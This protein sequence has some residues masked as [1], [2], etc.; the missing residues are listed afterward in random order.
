LGLYTTKGVIMSPFQ[1]VVTG[2][3]VLFVVAGV[4]IFALF[5]GVLGGGSAGPV[6]IWGT[7]DPER[8]QYLIESLRSQDNDFQDVTYVEKDPDTYSTELLNAMAAGTGP[9]LFIVSQEEIGSFGDKILA[10]PYGTFSQRD[11]VDAFID[12]GQLFLTS[13]GSLALPFMV[14]PLVMYWNRDLFAAST[15]ATPPQYWNELL[16][17]AP[18]LTKQDASQTITQSAVALGAWQNITNAK[19]LL[20]ALFLQAGEPITARAENGSLVPVFGNRTASAEL[21]A[22]SALRFYTEFGN[23]SKSNYTWNR[24]LPSSSDLFASGRLAIYFGFASEYAN[25]AERNPNLR[26]AVALLPQLQ[27]ATKATFGTIRGLAISRMAQ[28]PTGAAI[29]AQKLTAPVASGILSGQTGLPSVRREVALD[30]SANAA[31]TVFVQSALLSRAWIDPDAAATDGIFKAMI[32]SVISGSA[33]PAQA[34]NEAAQ[35]F[36][37]VLPYTSH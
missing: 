15:I 28:N 19:A 20:S 1:I 18:K 21:P 33:T 37:I 34:V 26:F 32:E 22:E 5:G 17:L 24:S 30:T 36:S 4:G 7:I 31:A 16:T 6:A 3:F 25:I 23:P 12:E 14:D 27:G 11:F 8:M 35:A 29:V 13:Q 2:L 10:L 9:D